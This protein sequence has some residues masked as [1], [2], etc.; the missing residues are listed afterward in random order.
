M[1]S[2][3]QEP[4]SDTEEH[5]ALL[6]T[7]EGEVITSQVSGSIWTV[8]VSEGEHVQAGQTLLVVESMKMEVTLLAPSSGQVHKLLCQAGQA[9]Q[10]GQPL[11]L[12]K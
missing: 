10:A 5:T 6:H 1:E 4:A 9:V 2:A 7:F 12:I 11:V 3:T 8:L